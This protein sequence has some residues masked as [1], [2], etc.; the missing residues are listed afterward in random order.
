MYA[1]HNSGTALI[2]NRKIVADVQEEQFTRI[3]HYAGL[4]LKSID[5]FLKY[6][7][8]NSEDLT[9]IAFSQSTPT[10]DYKLLFP[11]LDIIPAKLKT[12]I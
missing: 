12:Q 8:I 10:Y 2:E 3:K 5:Y 1:G 4:P 6:K 11:D 9:C 7:K